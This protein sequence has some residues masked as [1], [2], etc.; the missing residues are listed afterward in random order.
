MFK[1]ILVWSAFI[2]FTA[3]AQDA[4]TSAALEGC[5]KLIRQVV[6]AEAA[7]LGKPEPR[8]QLSEPI[9]RTKESC[10]G[11]IESRS[12]FDF[13]I[14]NSYFFTSSVFEAEGDD[15]YIPG[16]GIIA[17]VSVDDDKCT[18]APPK[19]TWGK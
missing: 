4:E 12:C 15:G 19:I 17:D 6:A 2:G 9:A 16:S 5:E 10:I 18:L 3:H 13:S 7:K 1:F 14:P 8:Y 11:P